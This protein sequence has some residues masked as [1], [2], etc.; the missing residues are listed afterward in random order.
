V[1]GQRFARVCAFTKL[2]AEIALQLDTVR[3][4]ADLDQPRR[5]IMRRPMLT[6]IWFPFAQGLFGLW[7][8]DWLPWSPPPWLT[9]GA[10]GD[11]MI[12]FP[13]A[14]R[15]AYLFVLIIVSV[16]PPIWI[17]T[18]RLTHRS[19]TI[20]ALP[21]LRLVAASKRGVTTLVVTSLFV[22]Q[23]AWFVRHGVPI[24]SYLIRMMALTTL[25]VWMITLL[26]PVAIV[27][28]GSSSSGGQL[29][30]AATRMMFP[31]RVVALLD[32]K[33]LG[34]TLF[35]SPSD[36][37]RTLLGQTWRASV[38]R[39]VGLAS[40]VIVDARSAT[41]PVC[42]EIDYMLHASRVDKAVF[43]VNDDGTAPGLDAARVPLPG[44]L[45]L[46]TVRGLPSVVRGFVEAGVLGDASPPGGNEP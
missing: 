32:G 5:E 10:A 12:R 38:H 23:A 26:P 16:G 46:C 31:F 1:K 28:T 17:D 37:L 8:F 36:N 40:L 20:G 41:P 33:L 21:M 34:P 35:F 6:S 27:L 44:P 43:V 14:A 9:E 15:V 3:R 24:Q 2:P 22:L 7:L 45:V 19:P 4:S 18:W 42:E 25:G 39:L 30:A 29:V 13:E 11:P